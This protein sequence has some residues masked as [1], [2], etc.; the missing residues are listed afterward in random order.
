LI[1]FVS[2]VLPD[3][4]DGYLARRLNCASSLGARLDVFPDA[5]YAVSSLVLFAHFKIIPAWFPVIMA[6]KL[7]EFMVTSR[8]LKYK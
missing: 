4:L 6:M 1:I 3:V 8:I 2:I 7:A 5:L